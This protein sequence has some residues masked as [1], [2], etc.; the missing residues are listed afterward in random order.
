MEII[1][2]ILAT[3]D[4]WP[5]WITAVTSFMVACKAITM[6]TPSTIDDEL[7]GK[8]ATVWNVAQKVLNIAALNILKAKN[9]DDV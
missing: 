2:A 9:A 3:V 1:T 6:L 4:Q 5:A 7:Y 8:V